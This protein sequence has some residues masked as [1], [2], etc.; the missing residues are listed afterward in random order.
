MRC[1]AY[2]KRAMVDKQALALCMHS[3]A[4]W[5]LAAQK[6]AGSAR[7]VRSYA[8]SDAPAGRRRALCLMMW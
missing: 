8:G 7:R 1:A 6:K 4:A 2:P 3:S 5:V